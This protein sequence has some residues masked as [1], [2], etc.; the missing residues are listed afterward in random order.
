MK[1]LLP[2]LCLPFLFLWS[3]EEDE[4]PFDATPKIGLISMVPDIVREFEDSLVIRLS[5][6]DGD[7]DLGG[8]HPD[9]HNLFL[10]DDRNKVPYEF[11]IQELV[12]NGENVPI[13]GVLNVVI[14]NM[15]RVGNDSLETT[16]FDIYAIDRAGNRSNTIVSPSIWVVK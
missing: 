2:I 16:H 12:P 6:E 1:R 13:K 9:S 14:K 11:R 5:Y 4:N 8:V 10:I 7:G 3:C 15:F